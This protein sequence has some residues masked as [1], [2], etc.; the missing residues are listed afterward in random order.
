MAFWSKEKQRTHTNAPKHWP[1][2]QL[3]QFDNQGLNLLLI[4]GPLAQLITPPKS[5]ISGPSDLET[6]P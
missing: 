6:N 1:A 5:T 4:G 2:V 3:D